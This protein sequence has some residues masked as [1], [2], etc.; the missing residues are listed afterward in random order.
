MIFS[1]NMIRGVFD[2]VFFYVHGA[3]VHF[4]IKDLRP[5]A[6]IPLMNGIEGAYIHW[7]DEELE[8]IAR[9]WAGQSVNFA[10]TTLEYDGDSHL[11]LFYSLNNIGISVS[12]KIIRKD[13][14]LQR[15][16]RDFSL[17]R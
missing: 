11:Y 13:D 10:G 4:L 16:P 3:D 6:R 7:K 17:I 9:K 5:I 2:R 12:K 14:K 1:L 15:A 8:E